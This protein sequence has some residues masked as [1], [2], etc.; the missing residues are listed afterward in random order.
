MKKIKKI[1]QPILLIVVFLTL[2]FFHKAD[3]VFSANDNADNNNE[4]KS[5]NEQI[6]NKKDELNQL[7]KKQEAYAAKIQQSQKDKSTLANQMFLLENKILK[8]ETEIEEN[9]I[10]VDKTN[11]E[12]DKTNLEIDN[13]NKKIEKEKNHISIVLN[14]LFKQRRTSTLEIM[15]MN[16]SLTDYL[17]QVKYLEDLNEEVS[18]S[19]ISVEKDKQ[20]LQLNIDKLNKQSKSLLSLKKDLEQKKVALESQKESKNYLLEEAVNSEI[21]FQQLL[22]QAKQ[23]Q[24]QASAEI[25]GLEKTVR[26]RLSKISGEELKFNDNGL[27]WPV[28]KNTV[29]SFFHD[30]EYPFRYLFEHP[31]IDIKAGQGTTIKASASGY[32]AMA[33][34]AGMGYNYIMLVHGDGLS[35]VYGHVSKLYV[36]NDEY[37]VQGQT[38]GLS[39]GLPGTPGAGRLSTGAHLHFEVRLNGIPVNPLEYL[40]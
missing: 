21:K 17:N 33:K 2:L 36:K 14:L 27:N 40:P 23:E 35:T 39:G 4:V 9:N 30:P 34:D 13:T 28:K 37:V 20:D 12:I 29:T 19:L 3:F 22:S 15:L 26:D 32:V 18:D 5:L 8:S 16:D 31:A 6:Q 11:L 10:E 25:S 38:I 7:K 24:A 1:Y